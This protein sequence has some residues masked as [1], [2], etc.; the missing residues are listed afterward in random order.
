MISEIS[1][2]LLT[3]RYAT[4]DEEDTEA[5]FECAAI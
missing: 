1:D 3:Y 4:N 2:K 5:V